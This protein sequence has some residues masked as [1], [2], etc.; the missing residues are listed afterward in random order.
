MVYIRNQNARGTGGSESISRNDVPTNPTGP[1]NAGGV[2]GDGGRALSWGCGCNPPRDSQ[3][4]ACAHTLM[5]AAGHLTLLPTG[6]G[7]E[8]TL[9]PGL[10]DA[11]IN[12]TGKHWV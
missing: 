1:R 3:I 4:L 9:N 8:S 7:P 11:S 12:D 10:L 2:D 6:R 5:P